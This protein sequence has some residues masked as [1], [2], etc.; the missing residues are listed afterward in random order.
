MPAL[1]AVCRAHSACAADLGCAAEHED[2]LVEE[3]RPC[4]HAQGGGASVLLDAGAFNA[5]A[6]VGRRARAAAPRLVVDDTDAAPRF[7]GRGEVAQKRD[8]ILNL[9]VHVNN[10]DGVERVWRKVW[11]AVG[12]KAGGHVSKSF[13]RHTAADGLEH[14]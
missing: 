7:Q 13:A 1:Y 2:V 9:R 10:Q 5:H 12:A 3:V 4:E 14:L 11:R 8:A 6:L